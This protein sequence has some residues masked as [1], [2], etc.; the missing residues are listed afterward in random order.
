LKGLGGDDRF[1]LLIFGHASDE[2]SSKYHNVT[3]LGSV[4]NIDE[5]IGICD[6]LVNLIATGGG[7]QNKT[8]EA[9]A[10]GC[11]VFGTP[12]AFRGLPSTQDLPKSFENA[13]KLYNDLKNL[14]RISFAD[15]S[16]SWV[17]THWDQEKH[18]R[19]KLKELE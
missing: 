17:L 19:A 6:A 15:K 3:F 18:S 2:C 1:E 12:A 8:I 16:S 10:Q 7:F 5:S 13:D 14:D 9:W 4:D 11:P